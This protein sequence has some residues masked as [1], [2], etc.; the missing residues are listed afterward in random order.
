LLELYPTKS[1]K[2]KKK[3]DLPINTIPLIEVGNATYLDEERR[4]D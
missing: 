2:L 4:E 1:G 3:R